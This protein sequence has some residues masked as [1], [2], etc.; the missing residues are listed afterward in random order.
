MEE[1]KKFEVEY[2]TLLPTIKIRRHPKIFLDCKEKVK[3]HLL[4]E[5]VVLFG[6]EKGK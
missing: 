3:L 5:K 6:V 1:A 2:P 4:K